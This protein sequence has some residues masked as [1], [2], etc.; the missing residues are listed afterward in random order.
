MI[1]LTQ[2]TEVRPRPFLDDSESIDIPLGKCF[3]NRPIVEKFIGDFA[4]TINAGRD[5][6]MA[7]VFLAHHSQ[8]PGTFGNYRNCLEKLLLWSWIYRQK[9]VINF[10][11]GD[12][13]DFISFSEFPP[14]SWVGKAP[15]SR[16]VKVGTDWIFNDNWKPMS[17][18]RSKANKN[19]G[20]TPDF[21]ISL[22]S[23][24]QLL[25]ISCS[26][27][28]FLIDEGLVSRNPIAIANKKRSRELHFA[29]QT[30][31]G[32]S[33]EQWGWV[34][35]TAENMANQ[36]SKYE[37]SLF[38]IMTIYSLY[39]R[40]ADL[41]ISL[42]WTPT[43]GAFVK[44]N[45]SWWFEIVNRQGIV[46]EIFVRPDFI[47]YLRRYRLSRSL[48]VLPS[49]G[50]VTPLLT[51][52]YGRP[53]LTDRQI[54]VIVQEVFDRTYME[55]KYSGAIDCEA[56]LSA[57]VAWLRDTG[58]RIDAQYRDPVHLQKDLRHVRL[59]STLDRYY[60]ARADSRTMHHHNVPIYPG[61]QVDEKP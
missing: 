24:R 53:G 11:S 8:A 42:Y 14:D 19:I 1:A 57:S 31:R 25:T 18:R 39:L 21:T 58:A 30:Q 37:R 59:C 15:C 12:V 49:Y 47:P 26:F 40:G 34:I 44:R 9:A 28:N 7:R 17:A 61:R 16:F 38:I 20:D 43:M 13:Q 48:S 4:T 33:D 6:E 46:C 29:R 41:S 35:D 22:G 10:S 3:E 54:R 2:F 50:E 27:F 51:T 23:I 45:E 52:I 5:F 56:L 55:M 60:P 36:N 32:L